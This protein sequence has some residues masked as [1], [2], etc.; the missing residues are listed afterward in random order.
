MND[1]NIT[2]LQVKLFHP[3]MLILIICQFLISV[4]EPGNTEYIFRSS[5]RDY[6]QTK[7]DSTGL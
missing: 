4:E 3:S 5:A 7:L 2:K 1:E 6:L